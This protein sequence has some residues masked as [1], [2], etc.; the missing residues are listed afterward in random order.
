VCF[1]Q[2]CYVADTNVLFQ[3]YSHYLEAEII[4]GS[5]SLNIHYLETLKLLILMRSVFYVMYKCFI[6]QAIAEKISPYI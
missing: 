4:F 3:S 5:I 1:V 6:P 2:L